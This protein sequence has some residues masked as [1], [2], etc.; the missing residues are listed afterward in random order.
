MGTTMRRRGA[1]TVAAVLALVAAG[2][3]GGSDGAAD[4]PSGDADGGAETTT[5]APGF[6]ADELRLD[7]IQAIGTHNSFHQ[8]PPP[9]ELAKLAAFDEAQAAQ[10]EYSHRPIGE[11]LADQGIRQLELDVF[12]DPEG[13]L[14]SSPAL[15]DPSASAPYGPDGS[16]LDEP[17]TKVLHEQDVDY[18]SVC[19]TFVGCLE[20]VAAWSDANPDHVPIAIHVQ[21]KDG[22]LIFP[23][24]DQAVPVKWTSEQMDALDEEIR[25]VFDPEDL[26]TPDAVRGDAASVEAAVL[27]GGWPTLGESRGKVLFAMIN[28]EPYR[29]IY[30]EGHEGL[31]GR[32]LFT[33]AE[34]GQPDAAIVGIDDPLVDAERIAELV[35]LGYLVRTRSDANGVE[36]IADDPVRLEAALASGAHWISTDYPPPDGAAE[37]YGTDFVAQLPGGL[38]ARCNP[39]TAPDDCDDASVER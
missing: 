7:Q 38:V 12:A 4:G 8:A 18:H 17:G 2:C 5:T 29:S 36:A 34:P 22:P 19:P 3:G 32:I 27:D 33:N 37:Q 16:P 9:D 10:R 14:Y 25:S 30:L 39:V 1:W 24:P 6:D 13:G 35:G 23:V 28:A 26:I 11:Q 21:F 15:R 20:E 31:A